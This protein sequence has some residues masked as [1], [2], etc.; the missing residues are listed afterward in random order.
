[1]RCWARYLFLVV[2][3]A[4]AAGQ[5]IAACGQKGDLY[6][7][8][9]EPAA[10]RAKQVPPGGDVPEVQ[11]GESLEIEDDVAGAN[12]IGTRSGG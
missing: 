6:L 12:A 8:K 10:K 5:W 2:V 9:P 4:L 11:T 3:A 7:P 1:M